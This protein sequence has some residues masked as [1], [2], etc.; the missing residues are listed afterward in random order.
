MKAR[1]ILF[2][3]PMVRAL[4]D[5]MKT[6]TRRTVKP[7]PNNNPAK[8]H[9]ITPYNTPNGE[10]N[11][12]LAATGHGTGDPFPCPYGKPGD[13]LWVRETFV[14]GHEYDDHD[15]PIYDGE[16][17]RITTWYRASNPDLRWDH[18]Y[19]KDHDLPPWK[20]S[21]HMPRRASRITLEISG[22]RV[23]RLQDI[24]DA[25]A[26]EEGVDRTNT[27]I[28]GYAKER[29]RRL[30]ESINGEGSWELNPWVWV[31]DFTV[32]KTNIDTLVNERN[33]A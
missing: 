20:P 6:Q 2:S 31:L 14:Q 12:V 15:M 30:W 4:L 13:L 17:M 7:Q 10:W 28:A 5:G 21:I 24:S 25:D 23:E 8:H 33:A 11:W 9:P 3:A 1:P 16:E 26:I 18:Y 32:H 22:V 29:Y 19:E 27:S